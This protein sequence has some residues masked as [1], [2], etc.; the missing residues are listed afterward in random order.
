VVPSL[1]HASNPPAGSAAS[2]AADAA[3]TV[4]RLHA[5]AFVENF[6]LKEL[7]ALYPGAR[8]S[9]MQLIFPGTGG[10]TVYLFA[11]GAIVFVGVGQDGREAELLR[12]R[13]ARPG[14]TEAQISSEDFVVRARPGARIDVA[15]GEVLLDR[16]TPDREAIVALTIAQSA[17]MEYYERI[18]DEMFASTDK[19]VDRLEKVG[20]MPLSTRHLHKFIGASISTRS[21]VLSILH[22]LD[23]PDAIWDDPD[24]ERLYE[25][26]RSELDLLDRYQALEHKLRS[27]QDALGLVTDIARD[28][29]L[30]LL[31]VSIV[32]LIVVEIVLSIVRH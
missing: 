9:H 17:A 1:P 28:R 21:E 29:R 8:R 6:N 13:R 23:K 27:V 30:V 12:W 18:V 15:D 3:A 26:M 4:H 14:L 5:G 7:S 20:T 25:Q 2:D 22:L 32:L 24:A 16:L 31:E 11:F 10:G 19:V